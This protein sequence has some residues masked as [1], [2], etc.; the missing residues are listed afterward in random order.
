[1]KKLF[2]LILI[3]YFYLPCFSQSRINERD[4]LYSLLKER[5]VNFEIYQKS[6]EKRSGF[7]GNRSKA[8]IKRSS[9]LLIKVSE[10]DNRIIR[11]LNRAIDFKNYEKTNL[12]FDL[13]ERDSR[14]KNLLQAADTLEK[15]VEAYK[16]I[17]HNLTIKSQKLKW[18][19][20]FLFA[21]SITLGFYLWKKKSFVKQ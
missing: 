20:Y 6:L 1:M 17:N 16:K 9:E 4:E 19:S 8:D 21:L 13:N 7:F 12:S 10:D 5:N 3:F 15:Q 14:L 11:L 2:A 18:I